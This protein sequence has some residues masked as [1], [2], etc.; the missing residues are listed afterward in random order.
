MLPFAHRCVA[1]AAKD[2]INEISAQVAASTALQDDR[3]TSSKSAAPGLAAHKFVE[4]LVD[5]LSKTDGPTHVAAVVDGPGQMNFRW[6]G[7]PSY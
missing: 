5:L 3:M 1:S 2:P 6:D 7:S 4:L